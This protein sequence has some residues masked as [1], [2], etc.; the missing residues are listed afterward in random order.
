MNCSV[1]NSFSN[2]ACSGYSRRVPQLA[3]PHLLQPLILIL[4]SWDGLAPGTGW[5]L[6]RAGSWDGLAPGM[7]SLLGRADSW[8]GLVPGMGWL[9]ERTR[10]WDGLAPGMKTSEI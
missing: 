8:D 9:L 7:G 5:L 6:G 3:E 2:L 10:S 1:V 4:R